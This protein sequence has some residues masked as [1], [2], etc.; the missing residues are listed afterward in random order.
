M[1]TTTERRAIRRLVIE[2]L[3][4]QLDHPTAIHPDNTDLRAA[5]ELA[6]A[7]ERRLDR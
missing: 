6:L 1:A 5:T 2:E 3:E 7:R 4:R